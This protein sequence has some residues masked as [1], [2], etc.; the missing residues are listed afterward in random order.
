MSRVKRSAPRW[1]PLLAGGIVAVIA[2]LLWWALK[3]REDVHIEHMVTAETASIKNAIS[4]QMQS[5]V[6]ALVEIARRWEKSGYL[7]QG[8]WEFEAE[9]NLHHFPGYHAIAWVDPGLELRWAVPVEGE[10]ALRELTWTYEEQRRKARDV[11]LARREVAMTRAVELANNEKGILVYVPIFQGLECAG[12]IVGVFRVQE[13]LNSIL[14]DRVAPHYG[15]AVFDGDT[16][17]YHSASERFMDGGQWQQ[18]SMVELY[19][20]L[21][22]LH[23]WPH[24][25]LAEK[26]SSSLPAVTLEAGL[27]IAMLLALAVSFA[28]TARVQARAVAQ[29]NEELAREVAERTRAE[30]NVRTL[31]DELEQ[32]VRERTAQLAESN[33]DLEREVAT[34]AR[35]EQLLS[36]SEKR[37]R[38][39]IENVSDGILSCTLEG[40]IIDIN[41]GL[42]VMLG[43]PRHELVGA[44]Y[45]KI[46]T[47]DSV[48][49][50]D[51]RMRLAIA[52]ERL[53]T[54]FETDMVRHDGTTVPVEIRARLRRDKDGQPIGAIA[55]LRDISARKALDRQRQEF[56][57]LLTHDI[58]SPLAVVL[59]YADLL[60]EDDGQQ[61]QEERAN[62]LRRLRENVCTVFSLVENYLNVSRFEDG[63][64]NLEKTQ[65]EINTLLTH[66]GRQYE[67]EA[68][69][70][71]VALNFALHPDLPTLQGDVLALTRVVS[72]LVSN[73]LKFTPQN[74][75]ITLSSTWRNGEII[76]SVA[77]TGPGIPVDEVPM[78]FEKYHRGTTSREV[79]GSGLGLF[80]AKALV[81]AHGGHIEVQTAP[82]Q[83]ANFSMVL[84]LPN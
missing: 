61:S 16:Q 57:T 2:L 58:K 10:D 25:S 24:P 36:E 8:A 53:P 6:L 21:W 68:R 54:L 41:W 75:T 32:R 55:T 12:V 23:I 15:V 49:R 69:Q 81:E 3:I 28:Q 9:L 71:S 60:L 67:V 4:A 66:V 77:D 44:H 82:D 40:I 52:G 83:G 22:R 37:Y 14:H 59:G 33:A 17:I 84:P 73:A 63:H 46:T 18:S 38:G 35:V 30:E 26:E 62:D 13:L 51:E 47:P 78:L 48:T 27:G 45:R 43:W 11:I 76:A 50:C 65:V 74:G 70:R 7:P 1:L 79:E 42:E 31:N 19:G 29:I 80:I 20:T 72:N 34:R 5:R 39:L 56:L 64:L